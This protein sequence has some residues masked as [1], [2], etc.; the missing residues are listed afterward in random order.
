[1]LVG[2]DDVRLSVVAYTSGSGGHAKWM[3]PARLVDLHWARLTATMTLIES[4]NL[5]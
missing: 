5:T 1:M 2:C 4:A 3:P